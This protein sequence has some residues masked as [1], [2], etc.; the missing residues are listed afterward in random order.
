MPVPLRGLLSGAQR[1]A[2]GLLRGAGRAYEQ[3]VAGADDPALTPGQNAAVRRQAMLH[4]GLM[5]I[6]HAGGGGPY[7]AGLSPVVAGMLAG[8]EQAAGMREQAYMQ[9]QAARIQQAL[10]DP[11]LA[12]MLSP[13]QIAMIRLMPPAEA[14]QALRAALAQADETAVVAPGAALVTRGGRVVHAQPREVDP[15]Q[16]MPSDLV[17]L[18]QLLGVDPRRLS[19]LPPEQRNALMT[20]WLEHTGQRAPRVTVDIGGQTTE[21]VT[22]IALD[23]FSKTVEDAHVARRDL[24]NLQVMRQFLDAGMPAGRGQETLLAL[25]QYANTLGLP[26]SETA[27]M[28]EAF[29]ALSN[30]LA[31]NASA[32]L[33]GPV[34]ERELSFVVQTVPG[35]DR[36]PA[37]NRLLIEI[38][39]RLA[40]RRI[41]MERLAT[42]YIEEHGVL[43][44][45]WFAFRRRWVEQNPLY[46]DLM[47]NPLLR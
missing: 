12:Q 8:R 9:T 23:D 26:I 7:A 24:A 38:L 34:S 21:G 25:R 44:H 45:R 19:E 32:L 15:M 41:E 42:E 37:G 20:K 14:A 29:Q 4:S 16:G 2:A 33:R 11:A 47:A 1:G 40:R 10:Q 30:F 3:I 18:A 6:L 13:H 36:T 35:L 27:G 46:E 22:K 43:D 31:L 17:G 5:S 28:Q 39:S